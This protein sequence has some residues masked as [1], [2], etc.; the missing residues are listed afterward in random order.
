MYA[1]GN[2]KYWLYVVMR[3]E[4]KKITCTAIENHCEQEQTDEVE[5]IYKLKEFYRFL[6]FYERLWHRAYIE[7][8]GN[9]KEISRHKNINRREVSERIR[10]IIEKCKQLKHTLQ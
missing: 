1:E 2:L 8:G 10:Y 9:Y 7:Y 4:L 5:P 3:N 6:N